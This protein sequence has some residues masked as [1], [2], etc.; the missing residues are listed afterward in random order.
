LA[1]LPEERS[2]DIEGQKKN[3]GREKK[4]VFVIRLAG[5]DATREEGENPEMLCSICADR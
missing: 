2:E 1:L 3:H 5:K 4:L